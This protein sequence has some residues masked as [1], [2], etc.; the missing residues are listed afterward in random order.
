MY[1]GVI[2]PASRTPDITWSEAPGSTPTKPEFD[3]SRPHYSLQQESARKC[4]Q[5]NRARTRR[6]RPSAAVEEPSPTPRASEPKDKRICRT[7]GDDDDAPFDPSLIA[8]G[9]QLRVTAASCEH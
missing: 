1:N 7:A 5:R 9:H 4:Q 2:I 8:Q 3:A 6:T